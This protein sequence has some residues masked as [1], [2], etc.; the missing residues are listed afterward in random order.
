MEIKVQFIIVVLLCSKFFF[1]R[2]ISNPKIENDVLT[3]DLKEMPKQTTLKLTD[4]GATDIQY[5]PLETNEQCLILRIQK[6]IKSN[7]FF[8]IQSF[9]DI[10]MF[11]ND[12]SYITKIG[13]VGRGPNEFTVAHDVNINPTDGTIYLIDGW[14]QKFLVYSNKGEFIRTFKY[15]IRAAVNFEFTHDGIL[16]Y[17]KNNNSNFILHCRR[18]FSFLLGNK[19]NNKHKKREE[20]KFTK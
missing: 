12:G 6:I 14:Q 19:Q 1:S 15:P 10:L 7:N 2:K 16:C 8:L 5:I 17:N 11:R 3:F 18:R 13:T 9:T 4:L 20:L